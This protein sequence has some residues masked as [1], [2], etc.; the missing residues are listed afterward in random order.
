MTL[1]RLGEYKDLQEKKSVCL[2]FYLRI[3]YKTENGAVTYA[4]YIMLCMYVFRKTTL[5]G[6]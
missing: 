4:E 2:S 6:F 1:D 3:Y 5:K